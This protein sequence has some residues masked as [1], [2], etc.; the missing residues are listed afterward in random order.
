MIEPQHSVIT[1]LNNMYNNRDHTKMHIFILIM[2]LIF[3][4]LSI[5]YF[6]SYSILVLF[7]MLMDIDNKEIENINLN[8]KEFK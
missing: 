4:I 7:L 8:Y 1:F 6:T 2:F 5:L 3:P